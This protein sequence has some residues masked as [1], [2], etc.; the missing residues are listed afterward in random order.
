MI[1]LLREKGAAD[2]AVFG[3]GIIPD[4]DIADLKTCGVLEIFTPGA[5]TAHVVEW[6]KTHIKPRAL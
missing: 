6:V 2:I 4:E 3:G 5:S 1:E